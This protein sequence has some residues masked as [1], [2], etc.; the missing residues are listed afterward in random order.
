MTRG[1]HEEDYH[2]SCSCVGLGCSCHW[3]FWEC[4]CIIASNSRCRGPPLWE[5]QRIASNWHCGS[6]RVCAYVARLFPKQGNCRKVSLEYG[7]AFVSTGEIPL[8]GSP[9]RLGSRR[10]TA[11]EPNE[12]RAPRLS[13]SGA[14]LFRPGGRAWHRTPGHSASSPAAAA[15]RLYVFKL[16]DARYS[17]S[18]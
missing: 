11:S 4:Q 14:Q 17:T 9:E 2:H 18:P 7:P 5:C 13:E 3:H 6:L 16:N 15:L 8:T 10:L 1:Q 12:K